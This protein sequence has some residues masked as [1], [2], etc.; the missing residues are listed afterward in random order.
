MKIR[1]LILAAFLFVSIVIS[2][3]PARESKSHAAEPPIEH[4]SVKQ[5]TA[6]QVSACDEFK[7]GVGQLRYKQAERIQ[8]LGI[9]PLLPVVQ[10]SDAHHLEI[11]YGNPSFIMT[12]EDVSGLLGEPNTFDANHYSYELGFEGGTFYGLSINFHQSYVVG[13]GVF[14]IF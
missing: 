8:S 14:Q 6:E 13:S 11:D 3:V 9:L 2:L 5:L 7:S 1:Y 12:R 10:G 4:F